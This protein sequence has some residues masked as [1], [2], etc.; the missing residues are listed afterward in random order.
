MSTQSG[1]LAGAAASQNT[2][3]LKGKF[4]TRFAALLLSM[5]A[6]L[7]QEQQVFVRNNWLEEVSRSRRRRNRN[8]AW[9]QYLRFVAVG[10]ALALPALASLNLGSSTSGVRWA[11]F[12]VSIIVT[13]STAGLQVFRFGTE[14]GI[15]E[16]YASALET[17]GWAYFQKAGRYRNMD[18]PVGAYHE[19][20]AAVQ[21]LHRLRDQKQVAEIIA[22]AAATTTASENPSSTTAAFATSS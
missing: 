19:F 22:A 2:F 15:D 13:L 11:T 6:N 17:E 7:N 8:R 1:S 18:Y 4:D 16:E 20:F 10:G 3:P 21:N 9:F 5:P 12:I 14:W